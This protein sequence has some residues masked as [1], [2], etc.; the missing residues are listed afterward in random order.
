MLKYYLVR[1]SPEEH[2]KFVLKWNKRTFMYQS[3]FG[4]E[5]SQPI[6]P[7]IVLTGP[8][9]KPASDLLSVLEQKDKALFEWM[10][11]AQAENKP[12]IYITLGSECVW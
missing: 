11:Q 3:F 8:V 4:F 9:S 5:K 6:P 2:K 12:I 10:N 7:N 1:P